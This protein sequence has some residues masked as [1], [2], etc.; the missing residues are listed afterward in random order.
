L[1][2]RSD[3]F[4]QSGLVI[5]QP[6]GFPLRGHLLVLTTN[7][8][9]QAAGADSPTAVFLGGC[10]FHEG[11]PPASQRM[12]AFMYPYLGHELQSRTKT[13]SRARLDLPSVTGTTNPTPSRRGCGG[14][15]IWS[16]RPEL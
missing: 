6:E 10:D 13:R 2:R 9:P 16:G 15:T 4:T 11:T 14:F 5:G 3:G 8:I 1:T 12:L 7:I